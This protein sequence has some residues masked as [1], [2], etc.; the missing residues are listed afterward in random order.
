MSD[1][2]MC[3]EGEIMQAA[4]PANFKLSSETILTW[5]DEYGEDF[6]ALDG[7]EY[8]VAE[9]L[10]IK[11]EL[12]LSEVQQILDSSHVYPI[13]KRL[14][15]KKVCFTWESLKEK[16]KEKKENFILLHENYHT[17]EKLQQLLNDWQKIKIAQTTGAVARLPAPYK[18]GR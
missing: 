15:D 5:N 13:I 16:Y 17:E 12:R 8:L 10:L 11:K 14:L 2:Y 9:A 6:T 7:E 3:T 4:L 1:Y 18:N